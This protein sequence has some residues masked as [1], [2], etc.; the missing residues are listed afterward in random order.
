MSRNFF[1]FILSAVVFSLAVSSCQ[2]H[3]R[4][5][6]EGSGNPE[7]I[8]Y[9]DVAFMKVTQVETRGTSVKFVSTIDEKG[10]SSGDMG[11]TV[12]TMLN[13]VTICVSS[14]DPAFLGADVESDDT[15]VMTVTRTDDSTYVLHYASTGTANLNIAA[16]KLS[17]GP[18]PFSV[19]P[20][21][22]VVGLRVSVAFPEGDKIF[23]LAALT[24]EQMKYNTPE[25]LSSLAQLVIPYDPENK[26]MLMKFLG[27]VPENASTRVVKYACFM[28][29]TESDMLY[30][31]YPDVKWQRS[32]EIKNKIDI[33]EFVGR[34]EIVG[35]WGD[36]CY[37]GDLDREHTLIDL[38]DADCKSFSRFLFVEVIK[39]K[40]E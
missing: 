30:E 7:W 18:I 26:P 32:G 17:I 15:S 2:K 9:P 28:G 20:A 29:Q 31:L 11:R 38:Y 35:P 22:N 4:I 37:D 36:Y 14:S 1:H 25:A 10:V 24:P 16:G 12:L 8:D 13:N 23:T 27:L 33:G 39:G 19:M 5:V 3:D 21:I 6:T 40:P 34:Y